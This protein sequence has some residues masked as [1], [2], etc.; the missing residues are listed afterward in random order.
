MTFSCFEPGSQMV[1]CDPREG[2]YS[3]CLLGLFPP[4]VALKINSK[5]ACALLYHGDV[6]PQGHRPL[7]RVSR[8]SEQ[9]SSSTGARP[10]LRFVIF[11]GLLWNFISSCSLLLT[12][13]YLLR[14]PRMCARWR[15]CEDYPQSLYA[16]QV[17]APPSL[18]STWP[19]YLLAPPPS[20]LP[21]DVLVSSHSLC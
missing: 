13:G 1:K 16:F 19:D 2:K 14:S 20:L 8:Q 5:V 12:A 7:L 6:A 4:Y 9:S 11:N 15:S 17:S 3:K 10:V 21:G 18:S